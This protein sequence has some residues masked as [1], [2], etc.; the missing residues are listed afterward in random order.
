M[1]TPTMSIDDSRLREVIAR[2]R[3]LGSVAVTHLRQTLLRVG[4]KAQARAQDRAP[5]GETGI[6]RRSADTQLSGGVTGGIAATV[7]FGGLASAYAEVQH[8]RDDFTHTKAAFEAKYGPLPPGMKLRGHKG[9]QAHF[10]WGAP[11]SAYNEWFERWAE[12]VIQRRLTELTGDLL[13]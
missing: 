6:L 3:K 11:N 2:G 8:E 10:L 7:T 4:L 13:G 1:P 9:G 12:G 5:V